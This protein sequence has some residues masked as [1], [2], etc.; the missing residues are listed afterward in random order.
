MRFE[1]ADDKAAL[2]ELFLATLTRMPN[3][4]DQELFSEY[5]QRARSRNVL[6]T[7]IFWALINTR[8]FILNH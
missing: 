2:E 8:E 5:R 1:L 7:D 3:A 6:F 4:G